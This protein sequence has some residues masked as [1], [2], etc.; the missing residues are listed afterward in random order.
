MMIKKFSHIMQIA[1]LVL[2]IALQSLAPSVALAHGDSHDDN[3]VRRD[4]SKLTLN[5]KEFRFGGTNNYYLMYSSQAMVDDVINKAAAQGFNVLRT[6]GNID[7]GNQ[8]GS[9]STNGKQNGIYFQY[10]DGTAPAYNDGADGMQKLDYVIYKAGQKG[11]KLVIPF[12]NNWNAFGG[13]DQYVRWANGQY[14]D[15][16]YSSPLIKGWFKNWINH[17]LNRVNTYNGIKYKDDPTIM[18][19][20]LSNEP[21]CKEAGPL[22]PR[23]ANCTTKTLV[24]WA[25]EMSTYTKKLD[26][27]HLVSVGDE[28]FYCNPNATDWTEN[29]GE[30]VDTIA[31]TKLK[32]I[33]VMSYH[34]YPELWGTSTSWGTDWINRHA[35][36][37]KKLGKAVMAGEFGVTNQNIRNAVYK[38]WTDAIFKSSTNGGLFW[39][40]A[41]NVDTGLPYPDYDGHNIYCTASPEC[42]TLSHFSAMMKANHALQFAPVAGN[43]SATT[44]ADTAITVNLF[45]NDITYGKAKLVPASVDLDPATAGIQTTASAYGGSYATNPDGSVTFTPTAG[46]NGKS[47][48][49]YTVKDSLKA[50]SNAATITITVKPS[51]TGAT[52]LYSFEFGLDGWGPASWDP[53]GTVAQSTTS[54]TEGTHSLQINSTGGWFTVEPSPVSDLT[55]GGQYLRFE[56]NAD[57]ASSTKLSFSTGDS[58][59]WQESKSIS[60]SAGDNVVGV[61][62]TSEVNGGAL[63]EGNKVHRIAIYLAPGTYYLDNVRLD[64]VAPPPP[65]PPSGDVLLYSFESG[66]QG[67]APAAWDPHGS[68]SQSNSFHTEGANSL[69][70]TTTG[71]GWFGVTPP[72]ISDLTGKTDL[73]FD[74]QTGAVGTSLS[75]VLQMGSGWTWCQS[76]W[77]S[78]GANTTQAVDID[79]TSLVDSSSN[80]CGVSNL[81]QIQAIYVFLDG[82]GTF[83]IDNVRVAGAI[84]TPP[85]ALFSFESGAEG[86]GPASWDPHGTVAQSSTFHTDGANGL[87]I[88]TTGDGWFGLDMPTSVDLTGKTHLKFDIQTTSIGTSMN[89]ALK[90]GSGWTWCQGS[91]G[92]VNG[93]TTSTVDLDLTTLTDSSSAPCNAAD[94][95]QVH[96]ILIF[97]NGGSTFY[98]DNVRSE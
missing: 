85:A 57:A 87:Q 48:I 38:T 27:N 78:V 69:Q 95:N 20:E 6:W 3:F 1:L 41:G 71:S 44:E 24:K 18:T 65:P 98:I 91:W 31:F 13:A 16:F 52:T 56:I 92:W 88:D 17:L 93:A 30:G 9:N 35:K 4:G 34:L 47:Q 89:V 59:N 19:W 67:W 40:L 76:P 50:V 61:D 12:T 49:T 97:L 21:R 39:M 26:K 55:T 73:K 43:D 90:I 74:L 83:N 29:C 45:P 25:D 46:F 72:I 80:P 5:G 68:L 81:G 82:G 58:W 94:L 63:S 70:I 60:L 84:V 96:S 22:Y 79:I 75:V 33:D 10:W 77:S 23:S 36:D 15:D 32:N 37:A 86:W 64:H 14:H 54:A 53:H 28:G 11:L 2:T 51:P 7:I 62:L 66:V 8:D 42:A